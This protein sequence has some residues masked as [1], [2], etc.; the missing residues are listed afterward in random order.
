MGVDSSVS[1]LSG[2][3]GGLQPLLLTWELES[4]QASPLYMG[5]VVDSSLFSLP[6]SGG[7][8]QLLLLLTWKWWW[9]PAPPP[10]LG[11]LV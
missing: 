5:V 2:R 9:I 10:Y 7:G 8:F 11:V 4:T 6:G 1:S 3:G